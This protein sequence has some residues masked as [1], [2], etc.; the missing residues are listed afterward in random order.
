MKTSI[1]TNVRNFAS[2]PTLEQWYV[3]YGNAVLTGGSRIFVKNNVWYNEN[4]ENDDD[5]DDDNDSNVE[6]DYTNGRDDVKNVYS[7]YTES[8]FVNDDGYNDDNDN[9]KGDQQL[10]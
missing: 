2:K 9:A 6:Y 10:P 5:S 7:T 1:K 3:T 8:K 4:V